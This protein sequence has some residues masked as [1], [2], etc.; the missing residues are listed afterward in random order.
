MFK[1]LVLGLAELPFP[2][3]ALL[4]VVTDD[5]GV[6]D[7]EMRTFSNF[8]DWKH[9]P[10]QDVVDSHIEAEQD[11][12]VSALHNA[13]AGGEHGDSMISKLIFEQRDNRTEQDL[14]LS[15]QPLHIDPIRC[16]RHISADHRSFVVC[17]VGPV[18]R[19]V[20]GCHLL[21]AFATSTLPNR[22]SSDFHIG[23]PIITDHLQSVKSRED[24]RTRCSDEVHSKQITSEDHFGQLAEF[25]FTV[26]FA[27]L[28][29][30]I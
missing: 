6:A 5:S 2:E 18:E 24:D 29:A 14:V 16:R 15:L 19:F 4:A 12:E 3:H 13:N 30:K 10:D 11:K 20:M 21:D 26:V 9:S 25:Q 8:L 1:R 17:R 27:L 23:K 22:R 28:E 7:S